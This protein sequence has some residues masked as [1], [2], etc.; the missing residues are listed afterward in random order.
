MDNPDPISM[1]LYEFCYFWR[2]ILQKRKSKIAKV[3]IVSNVYPIITILLIIMT[4][5]KLTLSFDSFLHYSQSLQYL[6]FASMLNRAKDTATDAEGTQSHP[7]Y[8][9]KLL[10]A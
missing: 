10:T 7:R 5:F 9:N 8:N 6:H 1:D 3:A 2:R 4:L